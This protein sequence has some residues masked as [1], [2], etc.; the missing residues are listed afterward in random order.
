MADLG[1]SWKNPSYA[2]H[3]LDETRAVIPF[4]VQQIDVMGRIIRKTRTSVGAFLDIG[5]GDGILGRTVSSIYPTSKGVFVDFSDTMIDV[6]KSKLDGSHGENVVVKTDIGSSAWVKDISEHAPFDLIVS[7]FAIHHQPDKRKEII[8]KEIFDLLNRG[9]FFLNL[10]HVKTGS[11]TAES[12]FEE[13]LLGSMKEQ[14]AMSG[15]SKPWEEIEAQWRERQADNKLAPIR[16]QVDWLRKIGF[17]DVDCYFQVLSLA[18][19][20]ALKP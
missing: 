5:C 14:I 9:G 11:A 4:G 10:E 15:K 17:I 16:T 7:G 3:F 8:Y 18:L 1:R 6:V 12:L 13:W 20:G 2:K 19:F